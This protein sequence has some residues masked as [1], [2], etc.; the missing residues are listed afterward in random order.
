MKILRRLDAI[1]AINSLLAPKNPDQIPKYHSEYCLQCVQN[2]YTL[3][4]L[5][6]AERTKPGTCNT[7]IYSKEQCFWGCYNPPSIHWGWTDN[8]GN[9]RILSGLDRD[10]RV[11]DPDKWYFSWVYDDRGREVYL[12]FTQPDRRNPFYAF[13]AR[14]TDERNLKGHYIPLSKCVG[15]ELEYNAYSWQCTFDCP[16]PDFG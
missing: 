1:A 8:N 5:A 15:R 9:N 10:Y 2:T 12:G 4:D 13:I 16:D 14:Y 11:D 7:V 3:F 6:H